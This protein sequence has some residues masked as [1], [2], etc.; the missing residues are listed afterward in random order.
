MWQDT[1]LVKN[2]LLKLWDGEERGLAGYKLFIVSS[3]VVNY[4]RESS[5]F[6][7]FG[8]HAGLSDLLYMGSMS[9]IMTRWLL[10]C[11]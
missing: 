7:Y 6:S 4:L 5:T 10:K 2:V 1:F 11:I 8:P 3:C 9:P